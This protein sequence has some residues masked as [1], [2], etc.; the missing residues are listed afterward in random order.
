MKR[1]LAAQQ[2]VGI[3]TTA[4]HDRLE[5]NGIIRV[6]ALGTIALQSYAAICLDSLLRAHRRYVTKPMFIHI[7]MG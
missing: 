1:R 5:V 6:Q 2:N 4:P 3:G 7:W